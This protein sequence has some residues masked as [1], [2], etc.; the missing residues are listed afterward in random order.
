MGGGPGNFSGAFGGSLSTTFLAALSFQ[1]A[2]VSGSA[3][4]H[5]F[6]FLGWCLPSIQYSFWAFWLGLALSNIASVF[7]AWLILLLFGCARNL[8]VVVL[9]R[10]CKWMLKLF[11]Y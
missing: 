5:C 6:G 9:L 4:Q 1:S 3:F 8:N 7:W 10:H 11:E 2:S